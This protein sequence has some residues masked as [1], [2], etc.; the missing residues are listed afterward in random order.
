MAYVN[1]WIGD[2]Y[3]TDRLLVLGESAYNEADPSKPVLPQDSVSG[4]LNRLDGKGPAQKWHR[5]FKRTFHSVEGPE[6]IWSFQT[7]NRFFNEIAYTNYIQ[8]SVGPAACYRPRPEQW[9]EARRP[10]RELLENLRPQYLLILGFSV[11][12]DIILEF[13][14][15]KAEFETYRLLLDDKTASQTLISVIP[16][17]SSWSRM[18]YTAEKAHCQFCKKFPGFS[19]R[20]PPLKNANF[21]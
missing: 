6:A 3:A 11:W 5:H 16:H 17:P 9:V 1:P 2:R 13:K 15:P 8:T 21:V 19:E 12:R 10:F 20:S 18:K 4:V 7:A 14:I